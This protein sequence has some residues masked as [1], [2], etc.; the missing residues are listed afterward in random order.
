MATTRRRRPVS[1]RRSS[2]RRFAVTLVALFAIVAV[3]AVRLVDI[4]IVQADELSKDA[5]SNRSIPS[6]IYAARGSIVDAD[7]TVLA[8]SVNRYDITASPAAFS[9]VKPELQA[10]RIEKLAKA[11][12]LD[13]TKLTGYLTDN[14]TSQYVMLKAQVDLDTR[15]AIVALGYSWLYPRLDPART[16]PNG[17]VAGNLVGSLGKDGP[18][19]GLELTA[20]SC[21]AAKNG[22]ETYERS[23][24]SVRLPGSTVT[25]T[26]A[27]D[28]GTLELTI[29]SDLQWYAQQAITAQAQDIDAKWATAV[30]VRVEDGHIMAAADYPAV[31]PNDIDG[32]IAANEGDTGVL[33]SGVFTRAYE[34]GSTFKPLTAS[35]L[36]EEGKATPTTHVDV[37]SVLT[38]PGGTIHDVSYH[39]DMHWTTT[40]VLINSSNIGISQLSKRLSPEIRYEYLK[41]FGI[42]SKTAVGFLG[43]TGGL[44]TNVTDWDDLTK[45]TVSFGQG[46]AVTSAQ[47]AS[48]YQTL[49]NGGVRMPLTL[50]EGC[51]KA[52]GTTTDTPSTKGT[53]VVSSS[54]A[55]Q[56]V[57]MMENVVTQGGLSSTLTIPGYDIAAKTGTAQVARNGVYTKDRVVSVAGLVPGDKP[58]YAVVVTFGEP[59]K[60]ARLSSSAAPTFTQI[61]NQIIKTYRISPSTTSVPKLSATW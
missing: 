56:V 49:G 23:Q 45:Y 29:D 1:A 31:D 44:L 59:Q 58:Q 9:A 18:T 60:G 30:I 17:G 2:G 61:M 51:E 24:D 36:I 55:R 34:P 13:V 50:V 32:T 5:A 47:V 12:D 33:T 38:V 28:G 40:G 35:A 3:F 21:L 46:V 54:T 39:P 25:T 6:T 42:G 15:N 4:Q 19:S 8:G 41:K 57:N 26:P 22:T 11:L 14:P 48:L 10:E 16:Y 52:D 53:R 37:P 27:I 20:N 43:E 7:G